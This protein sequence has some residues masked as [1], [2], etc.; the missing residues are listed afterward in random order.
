MGHFSY[1]S[2]CVPWA[3]SN[4]P[5]PPIPC[6]HN[7]PAFQTFF[8]GPWLS[9][10]HHFIPNLFLPLIFLPQVT[11]PPCVQVNKPEIQ[12]VVFDASPPFTL[13]SY[14][15]IPQSCP[16]EPSKMPSL[17]RAH[18]FHHLELSRSP[19]VSPADSRPQSNP[20]FTLSHQN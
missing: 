9:R 18:H 17:P 3:T 6:A 8:S 15:S 2:T 7:L 4:S 10:H 13:L 11:A 19:A 12:A 20:P 5:W 16:Q 1:V 14:S